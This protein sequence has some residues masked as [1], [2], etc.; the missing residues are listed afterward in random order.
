M[1]G[2]VR[3]SPRF[4]AAS[5]LSRLV[6]PLLLL[7]GLAAGLPSLAADKASRAASASAPSKSSNSI[8][9]P[10][11]LRDCNAQEKRVLDL[12]VEAQKEKAAIETDK[13]EITRVGADLGEQIAALDKTSAEA[14][15]AYNARVE[16]RDKLIDNYQARVTAF[17]LKAETVNATRDAYAK[18]CDKRRYDE[19]DLNDI[20]R[21]K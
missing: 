1:T 11:E 12:S 15:D 2:S 21:K 20:K 10:A 7:A 16:A 6:F 17:N 19:R 8:L 9:T 5:L 18:A 13:A 3:Y 14:V 4:M